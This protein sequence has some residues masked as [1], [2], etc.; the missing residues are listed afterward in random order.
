MYIRYIGA[1]DASEPS[2]LSYIHGDD[3]PPMRASDRSIERSTM[4]VPVC[5]RP[6]PKLCA[7]KQT[8]SRKMLCTMSADQLC[9]AL[10]PTCVMIGD[11]RRPDIG[12]PAI[13]FIS[14]G[15]PLPDTLTHDESGR[16]SPGPYRKASYTLGQ[17]LLTACS[18]TALADLSHKSVCLSMLSIMRP[19]RRRRRRRHDS[20]RK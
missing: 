14:P 2:S 4:W 15:D 8:C 17:L 5:R 6:Q 10:V 1:C 16:A 19:Q 13:H 11:P 20:D 12:G 18:H 3:R 9:C 7:I